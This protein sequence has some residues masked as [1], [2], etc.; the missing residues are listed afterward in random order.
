MKGA[1]DVVPAEHGRLG[2]PVRLDQP[3]P[4]GGV[5]GIVGDPAIAFE[6]AR[7]PLESPG[8]KRCAEQAQLGMGRLH[9]EPGKGAV[10]LPQQIAA[11]EAVAP[12]QGL[13]LQAQ[14]PASRALPGQMRLVDCQSVRTIGIPEGQGL[15]GEGP[16]FP[17]EAPFNGDATTGQA[18]AHSERI[19][20]SGR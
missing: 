8:S 11:R 20:Q 15:E 1:V 2:L 10:R 7:E 9:P 12:D 5:L 16:G 18:I 3:G 4:Q 14:S 19:D 6:A 13:V 17:V